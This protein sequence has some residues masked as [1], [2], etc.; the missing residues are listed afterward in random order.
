M[1]T[2]DASLAD[3]VLGALGALHSADGILRR[4]A[5][6]FLD[7]VIEQ[8]SACWYDLYV[9]PVMKSLWLMQ[10][11]AGDIH[12]L[13][14]VSISLTMHPNEEVLLAGFSLLT[15]T[16]G[17]RDPGVL[18]TDHVEG[19]HQIIGPCHCCHLQRS[20]PGGRSSAKGKGTRLRQLL[21]RTWL[22]VTRGGGRR[23]WD[24]VPST[25]LSNCS[26]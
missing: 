2:G 23:V 3:Q 15:H 8:V 22:K 9:I 19:Q 12:A 25:L 1:H 11:K 4:Q 20:R 26:T 14:S 13:L 16:V 18:M 24:I 21:S 5:V 6:E 10:L 7:Q 17:T